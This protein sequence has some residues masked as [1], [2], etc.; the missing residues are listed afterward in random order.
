MISTG[1]INL[2]LMLILVLAI[3]H[4]VIEIKL[5]TFAEVCLSLTIGHSSFHDALQKSL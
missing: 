1:I 3:R 2:W 5:V 4:V